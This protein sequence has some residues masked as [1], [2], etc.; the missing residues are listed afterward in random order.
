MNASWI[1]RRRTNDTSSVRDEREM[2]YLQN[3]LRP[4]GGLR[5]CAMWA[6]EITSHVIDWL[7]V[8][9]ILPILQPHARECDDKGSRVL[10][11]HARKVYSCM[12]KYYDGDV[13]EMMVC[14]MRYMARM[15]IDGHRCFCCTHT[16]Q[17]PLYFLY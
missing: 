10:E 14:A 15:A 11:R 3:L 8:R 9:T 16:L 6:L 4:G 1:R 5:V 2:I 7:S 17:Y 13:M 12:Q